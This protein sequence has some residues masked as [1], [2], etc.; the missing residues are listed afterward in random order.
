MKWGSMNRSTKLFKN[1]RG[2]IEKVESHY[3]KEELKELGNESSD[4]IDITNFR[5]RLK[6]RNIHTNPTKWSNTFKQFVGT[7]PTNCL[8]VFVHFL[9]LVLKE[10]ESKDINCAKFNIHD[11]RKHT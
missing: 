8:S 9:R 5:A 4:N 1:F 7:L 3:S 11:F 10:L 6:S 2:F